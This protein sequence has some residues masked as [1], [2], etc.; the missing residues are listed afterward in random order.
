MVR[1]Q[2]L[3]HLLTTQKARLHFN[4][5]IPNDSRQCFVQ[6]P[7]GGFSRLKRCDSLLLTQAWRARVDLTPT[8]IPYNALTAALRFVRVGAVP[9]ESSPVFAW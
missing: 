3:N 4:G 8:L 1:R 7:S 6:I 9:T 2:A 5:L